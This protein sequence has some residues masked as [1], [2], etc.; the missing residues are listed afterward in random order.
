MQITIVA[1]PNITTEA[2]GKGRPYKK[3]EVLY[4]N[5]EGKVMTKILVSFKNPDVFKALSEGKPDDVFEIGSFKNDETG[6]WDWKSAHQTGVSG[7]GEDKQVNTAGKSEK[8][9]VRVPVTELDR[10]RYIVRQSSLERAVET[11]AGNGVLTVEAVTKVAAQYEA[12]VFRPINALSQDTY[13]DL[14]QTT[15]VT[16]EQVAATA[17]TV[18]PLTTKA[19]EIPVG[20]GLSNIPPRRAPGRPRKPVVIDNETGE[21]FDAEVQ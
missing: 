11:L 15:H 1:T 21:L 5:D 13:L 20:E 7:N 8:A 9:P 10:N 16:A 4:R 3:M 6:Y 14:R 17:Q 19:A 18:R 12:W 2:G